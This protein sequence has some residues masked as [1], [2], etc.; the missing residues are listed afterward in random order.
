MERGET[1]PVPDQEVV[2]DPEMACDLLAGPLL[3]DA[4]VLDRPVADT[5][6][7]H[8]ADAVVTWLPQPSRHDSTDDRQR[9]T[10]MTAPE[11]HV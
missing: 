6:V 11:A 7:N 4:I 5:T 3:L 9:E 2:P 1:P 10:P 8:A